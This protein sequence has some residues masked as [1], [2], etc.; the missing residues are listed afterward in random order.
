VGAKSA[1]LAFS[2]GDIRPALLGATRSDPAEAQE[3]VRR[4]LPGYDVAPADE[5]TLWDGVN[6]AQDVTYATVLAGADLVCDWRLVLDRPS[7][8]PNHLLEPPMAG[9][10]SSPGGIRVPTHRHEHVDNL[11][12]LVDRPVHIP[13]H[14]VD[15]HI[16]FIDEPAVTRRVPGEPGGVGE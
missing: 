8:L 7:E 1:L 12:I 6:P 10:S 11:P 4:V 16:R 15:L 13:P 14:A 2:E 9:G 5:M 3:L